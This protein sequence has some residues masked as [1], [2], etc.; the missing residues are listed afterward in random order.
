MIN[1]YMNE[2]LCDILDSNEL[3]LNGRNDTTFNETEHYT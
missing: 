1:I 2:K 3:T